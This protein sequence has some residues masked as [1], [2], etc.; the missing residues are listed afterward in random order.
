MKK[1]FAVF[2]FIVLSLCLITACGDS[3]SG[4][5]EEPTA[6]DVSEEETVLTEEQEKVLIDEEDGD[7]FKTINIDTSKFYGSWVGNTERAKFM[8]GNLEITINEDGT[9]TGNITDESIEG[10]WEKTNNGLKLKSDII[11]FNF[12]YSSNGNYVLQEEDDAVRVVLTK[13]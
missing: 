7:D 4:S 8:Y 5:T 6:N 2:M 9:W 13:K 3:K 1:F 10:T 12:V 11:P